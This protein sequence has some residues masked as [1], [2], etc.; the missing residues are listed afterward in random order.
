[1]IK[2]KTRRQREKSGLILLEGRRL[3]FDAL[4]SGVVT[5]KSIYFS[6]WVQVICFRVEPIWSIWLSSAL[7][8]LGNF[9]LCLTSVKFFEWQK[10]ALLPG[11]ISQL[12]Q[13]SSVNQSWIPCNNL[14]SW[15]FPQ[16]LDLFSD[17][18]RAQL[19]SLVGGPAESGI[20]GENS[21]HSNLRQY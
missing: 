13:I 19:W 15:C 12:R 21:S 1:M 2:L 10:D 8:I 7:K 17:S 20:C 14:M 11:Q 9:R 5:I 16:R 4:M 6:E 3:I 18:S